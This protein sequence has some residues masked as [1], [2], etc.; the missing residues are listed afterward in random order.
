MVFVLLIWIPLVLLMKNDFKNLK[1][2]IVYNFYN[3]YTNI[4]D[5]NKNY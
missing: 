2:D 4:K 5:F 1:Y 3:I